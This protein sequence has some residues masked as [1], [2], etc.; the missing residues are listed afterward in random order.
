M[1]ECCAS[2]RR[3]IGGWWWR[4]PILP[5]LCCLPERARNLWRLSAWW[6]TWC[7]PTQET[8][9]M[10]LRTPA[11][12]SDS[13]SACCSGIAR[14]DG[15]ERPA[16]PGGP[17]GSDGRYHCRAAR[18]SQPEAQHSA[19]KNCLGGGIEVEPVVGG[20]SLRR[21]P[22]AVRSPHADRTQKRVA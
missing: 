17:I 16:H 15:D 5:G 1:S 22:A 2:V 18:G 7:S 11:S 13:S 20:E 4:S 12:Q 21:F 9:P 19:F 10:R 6:I 3:Q 14:K 8:T